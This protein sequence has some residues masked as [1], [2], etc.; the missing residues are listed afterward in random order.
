MYM[1]MY[2]YVY[3]WNV[4]SVQTQSAGTGLELFSQGDQSGVHTQG[5]GAYL[6]ND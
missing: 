3:E 4:Y 5:R 2:I 1:Y 6:K